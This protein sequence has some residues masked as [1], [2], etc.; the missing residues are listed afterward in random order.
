MSEDAHNSIFDESIEHQLYKKKVDV[1]KELLLQAIT[2]VQEAQ[3]QYPS[4]YKEMLIRNIGNFLS[5]SIEM[6]EP[7]LYIIPNGVGN[8][9]IT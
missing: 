4:E 7:K 3:E 6:E 1:A 8:E 2:Y 9:T 5:G